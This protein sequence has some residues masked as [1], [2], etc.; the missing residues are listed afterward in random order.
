L[1]DYATP[2]HLTKAHEL[3]NFSCSNGELTTWLQNHA[4]GSHNGKF[5]R[6]VVVTEH[7]SNDVVGYYALALGT[8]NAQEATARMQAGGGRH[9]VPVVVLARLAVHVDHQGR[10][11]G[12]G[13][14]LDAVR[15]TLAASEQFGGRAL[16]VHAKDEIAEAFYR[17]Q[18]PGFVSLPN[19][20]LTLSL[21]MKDIAASLTS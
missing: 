9:P 2:V 12:S 14:L 15:R 17:K 11:L 6:V 19:Q 1:S 18:I 4:R 10:G 7:N 16:I 5:T 13:L 20:P 8:V 3:T 21:L